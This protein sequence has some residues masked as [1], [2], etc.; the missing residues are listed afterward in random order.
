MSAHWIFVKVNVKQFVIIIGTVYLKPSY[1]MSTALDL[2]Q[3]VLDDI[4]DNFEN[5]PVLLGGDF[6]GRLGSLCNLEPELFTDTNLNSERNSLDETF[7]NRG[8]LLLNFMSRNGFI[9]LNGRSKGDE[10]GLFTY[11]GGSGSSTIDFAWVNLKYIELIDDFTVITAPLAS[12]HFPISV[13][14]FLP[15]FFEDSTKSTSVKNVRSSTNW[16]AD[17]VTAF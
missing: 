8:I 16:N 4:A 1:D 3:I 9:L 10:S 17:N 14:L 15:S 11:I 7:N 13:D 6:N 12:D 2:L 5:V